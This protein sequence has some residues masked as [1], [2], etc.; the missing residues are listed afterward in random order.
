MS[1]SPNMFSGGGGGGGVTSVSGAGTV[2]GLTLTGTVTTIGSITLGG[3]LSTTSAALTDFNSA[4]RAQVET[5]LVAGTNVTIT[6]SGSGATRQL[7]IAAAAALAGLAT[8]TVP[9]SRI[10]W[11]ETVAATGVTG[12]SKIVANLAPT[13]D[14]DENSADL[15]PTMTLAA[16]PGTNTIT[17]LMAFDE[18]VAGPIKL[19]WS[20]F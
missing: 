19:N 3:S 8:V 9:N 17:F 16:T 10:E 4:S 2:A 20:A 6:P 12:T 5:A 14:S 18:P 15:L 1:Y 13:V 7:T 11:E